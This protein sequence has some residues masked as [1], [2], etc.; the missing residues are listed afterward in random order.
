MKFL[1]YKKFY[2]L[3]HAYELPVT[4]HVYPLI[5]YLK[6]FQAGKMYEGF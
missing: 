3:M 4:S 6:N 1:K 5:L 2:T